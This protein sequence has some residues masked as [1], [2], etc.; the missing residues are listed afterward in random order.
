[1]GKAP[2]TFQSKNSVYDYNP[3]KRQGTLEQDLNTTTKVGWML[4]GN[5]VRF[6]LLSPAGAAELGI[7]RFRRQARYGL[8]Y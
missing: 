1:L 7:G 5:R 6:T 3:K 2:T 8:R 4:M